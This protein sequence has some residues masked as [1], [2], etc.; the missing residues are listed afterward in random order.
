MIDV[1]YG[2]A[3][4]LVFGWLIPVVGMRMLW[5]SIEESGRSVSNYR[6][7]TVYLGLGLVWLFWYASMRVVGPSGAGLFLVY[8]VLPGLRLGLMDAIAAIELASLTVI[9]ALLFGLID[10]MWGTS[11]A[12]GFRGHLLALFEG[13]ITT[14]ALKLFGI[15][16]V[17]LAGGV[18]IASAHVRSAT[19]LFDGPT[20]TLTWVS[21]TLIIALSANL[22]NLFDLRPGRALKVYSL[23]A[24]VGAAAIGFVSTL[25]ANDAAGSAL[26]AFVWMLG[27]VV[28]VWRYDLG[29]RGMLGDAGANAAG[30]LVGFVLAWALPLNGLIIVAVILLVLNV[31]SERISFSRIIDSSRL[32]TWVDGLGRA[33]REPDGDKPHE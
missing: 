6:G 26:V 14:G 8:N 19:G 9:W 22:M 21:A 11:S 12:R 24:A 7:R 1:A 23:Y 3:V 2:V 10:D 25:P 15:G 32:L 16:F 17:S 28:A 4:A 20:Y 30:V 29:E 31:L 5:P 18:A 13:R 27:P 33:L